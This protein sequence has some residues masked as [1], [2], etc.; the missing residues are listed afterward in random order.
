M[1]PP[2]GVYLSISKLQSILTVANLLAHNNIRISYYGQVN[3]NEDTIYF[4]VDGTPKLNIH[5][6]GNYMMNGNCYI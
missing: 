2:K 4:A 1:V 6:N 3:I 5:T